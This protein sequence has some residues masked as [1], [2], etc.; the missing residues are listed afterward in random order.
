MEEDDEKLFLTL[1]IHR[2]LVKISLLTKTV[3]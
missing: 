1:E 2:M 3:I